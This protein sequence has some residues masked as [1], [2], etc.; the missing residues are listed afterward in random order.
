MRNSSILLLTYGK[1]LDLDE[2]NP[3]LFLDGVSFVSQ[4]IDLDSI[5]GFCWR[6]GVYSRV[7]IEEFREL[8]DDIAIFG[9]DDMISMGN[10]FMLKLSGNNSAK[11]IK[12]Y[13]KNV[14][15]PFSKTEWL[16]IN[17]IIEYFHKR[18]LH[19]YL[20]VSK[21]RN[22]NDRMKRVSKNQI[23]EALDR[24]NILAIHME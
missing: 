15:T 19:E 24:F 17:N 13:I 6:D 23:Q 3:H 1:F 12:E 8:E 5:Y 21:L 9:K 18:N 10:N 22:I 16:L 4:F 20:S 7:L 2:R 14:P 11:L